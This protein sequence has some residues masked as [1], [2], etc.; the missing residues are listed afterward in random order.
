MKQQISESDT[1]LLFSSS[2]SSNKGLEIEQRA[3]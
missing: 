2:Q 1:I 3:F